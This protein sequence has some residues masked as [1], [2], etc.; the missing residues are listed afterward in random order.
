MKAFLG[1]SSGH[2]LTAVKEVLVPVFK[3]VD[4]AGKKVNSGINAQP[5][6]LDETLQGALNRLKDLKRMIGDTRY[7]LLAAFE[8]GITS[9]ILKDGKDIWFDLAWTVVEDSQGNVS[10]APSTGVQIDNQIVNEMFCRG[11]EKVTIG[12]ILAEKY[13][14]HPADPHELLTDKLLNRSVILQ[15]SL[16]SALGQ[17][18]R[19]NQGKF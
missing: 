2:N 8:N 17:L 5:V 18:R 10:F 19:I 3:T 15:Q 1:S 12:D 9:V 6:G 11:Q 13:G 7:D 4:L 14:C 16:Q